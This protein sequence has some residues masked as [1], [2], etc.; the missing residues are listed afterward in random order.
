MSKPVLKRFNDLRP[1]D[2]D[3]APVWVC[4]YAFDQEQPWHSEVDEVTYRPWHGQLP[5][6]DSARHVYILSR[7][8][9]TLADGGTYLGFSRP[10]DAAALENPNDISSTQ[11]VIFLSDGTAAGLYNAVHPSAEDRRSFYARLGKRKEA[12]FPMTYRLS[13][14]LIGEE[15]TGV[16][17]GFS[18]WDIDNHRV[19]IAW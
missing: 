7:A 12:V 15:F 17:P 2:F 4:S 9:L 3:L 13:A 16:I 10:P 14:D 6:V 1:A 19:S 8:T 11:P 18:M 5:F